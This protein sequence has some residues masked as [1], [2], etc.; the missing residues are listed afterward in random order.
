MAVAKAVASGTVSR[1]VMSSADVGWSEMLLPRSKRLLQGGGG[2]ERGVQGAA[3]SGDAAAL[4]KGAA[5]KVGGGVGREEREGG[6][7]R[8][9]CEGGVGREE[10]EGEVG[11]VEHEGGVGREECE[12]GT[13]IGSRPGSSRQWQA[14][15]G[16][17]RQW[18]AVAGSSR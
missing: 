6:V 11:R 9:D 13:V 3:F 18:Q 12:G 17:S 2:G 15:A 1:R 5:A 14:V 7:G 4:V 8:E 16:S 10:Y